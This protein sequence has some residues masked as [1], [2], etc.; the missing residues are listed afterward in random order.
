M[1]TSPDPPLPPWLMLLAWLSVALAVVVLFG[2]W[3]LRGGDLLKH[4]TLGRWIWTHGAVTH[5]DVFSY[6]S[7]GELIAHSWLAEVLFY[8][9]ERTGCAPHP[10]CPVGGGLPVRVG[11]M[12]LRCGLISVA[13]GFAMRTARL[14]GA[15]W[16]AILLLSPLTLFLIWGRLEFRPQLFSSVLLAVTLWLLI[17]VH[18]GCRSSRWLWL[19]PPMFACWINLHGGW[20]QGLALLLVITG[21]VVVMKVRQHLAEAGD[22]SHLPLRSLALVIVGCG[23]ALCLNPYGLRLVYFPA[24]MQASW[25][26]AIGPEW[27]SPWGNPTWR[28]V[29][30]GLW[31]PIAPAFWVFLAALA[32]VWLALVWRWRTADLIPIA[33]TGLWAGLSVWH[34]RA[35]SDAVLLTSPFLAAAW[36]SAWWSARRWPL[37]AGSGLLLALTTVGLWGTVTGAAAPAGEQELRSLQP[38]LADTITR[39]G[40]GGR[41][42]GEGLD[43][44]LLYRFHPH[45]QVPMLWEYASGAAKVAAIYRGE[46]LLSYVTRHQVG[47]MVLTRQ[48]FGGNVPYIPGWDLVHLDAQ[49]FIVVREPSITSR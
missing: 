11:F 49:F 45:L 39:L 38:G 44:W 26:R 23:L 10:I 21:A 3:D 8:L 17:S 24:E 1:K 40:L 13:L 14:L 31:L 4:L 27:Q 29:G 20:P 46:P 9:I 25:I 22:T 28:A 42:Y 35:V 43:A 15:S 6:D 41:V 47:W 30:A 33:V 34:L 7:E 2:V 37:V 18:M 19:L 36:P 16:P 32:G 12:V 5:A 48:R